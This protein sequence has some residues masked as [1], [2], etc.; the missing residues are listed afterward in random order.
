K[1]IARNC[2][3]SDISDWYIVTTFRAD[4][5]YNQKRLIGDHLDIVFLGIVSKGQ[6]AFTLALCAELPDFL[7]AFRDHRHGTQFLRSCLLQSKN[8]SVATVDK[9]MCSKERAQEFF[10]RCFG[11]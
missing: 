1:K 9:F 11:L 5:G 3:R 4:L 2:W 10:S 7:H 8:P 6:C